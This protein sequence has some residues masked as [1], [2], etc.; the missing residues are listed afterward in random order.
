M[1]LNKFNKNEHLVFLF[2]LSLSYIIPLIVFNNITLFYNDTLDCEIIYNKIIGKI[3]KGDA[4][5]IKIFLNE[6]I[7]IDY[8]RRAFFPSMFLYSFLNT[9][10]A[11]WTT[12][13]LVKLISYLSFFI[14][15]KKINKNL[16]LCAFVSCLYASM[17]I[18]TWTD[19]GLAILPYLFY[20]ILYKN[21]LGLK[22]IGII[23]FFGINSDV[24]MTGMFIPILIIFFFF[25]DKTKFLNSL[26]VL[27]LFSICILAINWHLILVGLNSSVELHRTE[28]LRPSLS[29]VS[30]LVVYFK[31]LLGIPAFDDFGSGVIRGLPFSFLKIPILIAFFLTNEKKIKISLLAIILTSFFLTLLKYEGI[32]NLINNSDNIFKTL[33]WDYMARAEVFFYALALIYILKKKNTYTRVLKV[34]IFAGIILFQVNSLIVPFVKDKIYKIENYQNLFTFDG[35]YNH[36]DYSKIKKIVKNRRIISVGIDPMVAVYHDIYV[37][38]GYHTI[39]PLPY[40]KK[41]RKIIEKELEANT[42]FKNYFDNFGSRVYTTF[43]HPADINNIQ[44]NFK[45]AKELGAD[46]VVSKYKLTDNDIDLVLNGCYENDLCLYK[47]N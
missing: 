18:F 22:H 47:I 19:F 21:K 2:I 14:L 28:F 31:S 43:Y 37:M 46:F 26:K 34:F 16:F 1:N 32:A 15:A 12:D 17:N 5:S 35:Y 45:V 27:S 13:V 36:Y 10:L 30:T 25:F 42:F 20:L 39:Y 4:D 8:L 6:E 3:L 23:I 24:V 33:S 7:K 44:L 40:K 29:L 11:Y 9:E 41:F 38:D